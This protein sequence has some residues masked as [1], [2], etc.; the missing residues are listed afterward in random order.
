MNK[1][2]KVIYE[3]AKNKGISDLN[4]I[5]I[6]Q[7]IDDKITMIK[8]LTLIFTLYQNVKSLKLLILQ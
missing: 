2:R 1:Y 8:K 4:V 6:S 3:M 5:Q 7:L